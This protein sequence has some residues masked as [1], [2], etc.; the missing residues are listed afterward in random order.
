[1]FIE[2]ESFIELIR[3]KDN[4]IPLK[5]HFPGLQTKAQSKIQEIL[6]ID[7]TTQYRLSQIN[8]ICIAVHYYANVGQLFS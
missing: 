2:D 7:L 8:F 6:K 5:A 4:S 1:M 3:N